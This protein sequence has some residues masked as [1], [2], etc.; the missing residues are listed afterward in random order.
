MIYY[1]EGLPLGL[2][3]GRSYQLEDPLQRTQL[4]SGR[5]R[6]RRRFTSVPQYANIS[7]LFNDN[8]AQLFEAWWRDSLIDGS[9]W[10]EYPLRT[11][12]GLDERT[13][14]FTSVYTGPSRV[15][16]NLWSY[17]AELE[18]RERAVLPV[19]CGILPDFVLNPEI[20][21]IAMNV[22][23]PL[24]PWQVYILETDTAI[25]QEWPTP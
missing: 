19:G 21:D 5:A 12:L 7:W 3:S 20:F 17:S 25:N 2:Q 18:L 1:P 11:P 23:W 4:S 16:P 15:G 22:K 14:R 10:F 8:Q 24:N 6:Q 9:Q 13:S